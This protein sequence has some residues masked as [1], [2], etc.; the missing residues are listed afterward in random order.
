MKRKLLKTFLV[1]FALVTGSMGVKAQKTTTIY[2]RGTATAPWTEDNLSD[3]TGNA[4]TL[5]DYGAYYTY[6]SKG[7]DKS[8]RSISIT[9]NA[10]VNI[11]A[12][13]YGMSNITSYYTDGTGVYF[14]FGN[15]FVAQNDQDKK[16]AYGLNG[17]DNIASATTFIGTNAYRNYDIANKKFLHIEIEI[18]TANNT[19]NY[20]RVSEEG[21][22]TYLVNVTDVTLENPDYSTIEWG[23]KRGAKYNNTRYE[24]LKSIV[25]KETQQ[26][27]TSYDY[28]VN[29]VDEEGNVIK[30]QLTRSGIDG[31]SIPLLDT[32]KSPIVFN[33]TKYVYAED[34]CDGK[35]VTSEGTEVTV[36]FRKAYTTTL[37]VTTVV[38]GVSSTTNTNL[39]EAD[40][41][42][43]NW[44]YTYPLYV[45][46][47]GVY[48]QADNTTIFGEEGTF[49]NG[50][51]INKTVTYT[52]AAYDVVFFTENQASTGLNL[53]Y[54]NGDKG[55]VAGQNARDRGI[56]V[57]TLPAGQYSFEVSI[58]EANRRSVCLRESANDP[59]ASVGTSTSDLTTGVKTATFT[60]DTE[61]SN[62][63]IN[64]ANAKTSHTNQSEEFDYAVIRKTADL[65]TV[66]SVGFATYSP[67]S[68]VAVPENV[69]VYT[70]T[71]NDEQTRITL[72]P[73]QAGTVL[74]AGTGYVIEATE[75]NYPFAVSNEAVSKIGMNDLLVSQGDVTVAAGQRIYVLA[76]R[77]SDESVGFTKVAEG[78]TIPAGKAY[79]LLTD[80]GKGAAPFLTFG[81][82]TTAVNGLEN[83][84]KT[85]NTYYTL[86][87]MKTTAPD[88]GLYILNGKKVVVK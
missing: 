19:L 72:S 49:N 41:Y 83:N 7:S 56:Y 2:E 26:E 24:Y 68:N 87:G 54:S 30:D 20:F 44:R 37:N 73:V 22:S 70:V 59:I 11:D 21:E 74:E 81:N 13:W 8:T 31:E 46:Q 82:E 14:R 76:V 57:G 34:D 15:I 64:G 53:N 67:S 80:N 45:K 5:S 42:T 32:D 43:C 25:I 48:Y 51:T 52:N 55:N 58:V 27:V 6:T 75:G 12:Y 85:N 10:I 60:L 61:T 63:Y 36:K 23:F 40:D 88:K 86:Q 38:N 69:T 3:F 33:D 29:Y 77:K 84:R 39:V 78:V 50:E 9:D 62:L 65:A 18:N 35:T 1:A 17:I 4:I 28:K 47:D 71:V 16:H 79:L 66:S